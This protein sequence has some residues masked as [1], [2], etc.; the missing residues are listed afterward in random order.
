MAYAHC[1]LDTLGYRHTPSMYTRGDP[2]ITR[3]FFSGGERGVSSVCSL[4]VR[5][6]DCPPHQLAKRRP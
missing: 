3:I 4:L 2:K 6:L 5:V 1:M